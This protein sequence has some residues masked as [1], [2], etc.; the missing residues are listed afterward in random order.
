MFDSPIISA[1]VGCSCCRRFL[2]RRRMQ[3]H[4]KTAAT[5][6]RA[7]TATPTPIPAFAP[8]VKSSS[9]SLFCGVG[10]EVAEGGVSEPEVGE[11]D[12]G[13]TLDGGLAVT[14]LIVE[15]LTGV[16]MERKYSHQH[17]SNEE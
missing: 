14:I 8:V 2:L 7:A 4:R 3:T 13:V 16:N 10:V 15:G 17:E 6:R 12:D 9:S 5:R 11:A 1:A